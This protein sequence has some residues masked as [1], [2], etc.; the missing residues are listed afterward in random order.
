MARHLRSK[1]VT[2]W[3]RRNVPL[4]CKMSRGRLHVGDLIRGALNH[5]GCVRAGNSGEEEA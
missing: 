1:L 2:A 5:N 3:D 4:Y